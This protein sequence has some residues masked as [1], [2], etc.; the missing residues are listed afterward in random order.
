MG[1]DQRSR[2]ATPRQQTRKPVLPKDDFGVG[3]MM[4][5]I[6]YRA[7]RPKPT[8]P[9]L[10][11]VDE[12]LFGRPIDTAALHPE[13]RNIYAASFK[14]LEEVDKVCSTSVYHCELH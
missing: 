13:V 2:T 12:I 1:V 4:A 11:P 3:N 9:P 7:A 6:E 8:V 5:V 14:E 10:D